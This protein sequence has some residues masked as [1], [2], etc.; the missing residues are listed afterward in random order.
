MQY[1]EFIG[2]MRKERDT[3]FY[4][5]DE[6]AYTFVCGWKQVFAGEYGL[7]FIL[8]GQLYIVL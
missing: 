7:P 1:L 2:W 5:V 3:Q 8:Q 4:L 6:I